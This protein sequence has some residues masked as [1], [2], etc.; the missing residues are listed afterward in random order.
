MLTTGKLPTE[1][2]RPLPERDSPEKEKEDED[3][4]SSSEDEED[5][6]ELEA[7]ELEPAQKILLDPDPAPPLTKARRRLTNLKLQ[8]KKLRQVIGWLEAELQC[9]GTRRT[10]KKPS[11]RQ[12]RRRRQLKCLWPKATLNV[13]LLKSR[14]RK[15]KDLKSALIRAHQLL[16]QQKCAAKDFHL[17]GPKMLEQ[18]KIQHHTNDQA[19]AIGAFWRELWE[20]AGSHTPDHPTLQEWG[21]QTIARMATTDKPV[22]YSPTSA[23]E[24]AFKRLKS[25][26]APGP[27][28]IC[29]YW[30]KAFKSMGTK[31]GPLL[32]EHGTQR[33][34]SIPQW[35][36]EGR[37]VLL[38]KGDNPTKPGS[39]RP[40][41]CLNVA[42]KLL[43]GMVARTLLHHVKHYDLLPLE[44]KALKAGCR[45]CFDAVTI[46]SA[47]AAKA[48]AERRDLSMVWLDFQKAFDRVPH[49]W[50]Q[51]A[52]RT[53]KAPREVRRAVRRVM[54]LWRTTLELHGPE[55]EVIR[56]PVNFKRGIYQGDT[57]SPLL[58]G[59]AIAP[60]STA[61]QRGGGFHSRHH[62]SPITHLVYMDDIKVYEQSAE[63]AE[64]TLGHVEGVARAIGMQL[65]AA[66]C[67][68]AHIKRGKVVKRGGIASRI[69]KVNEVTESYRYLGVDQLFGER[70]SNESQQTILPGYTRPGER[71]SIAGRPSACTTPMAWK[72][73]DI[74]AH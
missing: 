61:L 74:C 37:T 56:I 28:Q 54:P 65:G 26:K 15:Q 72:C 16:V 71:D 63:E 25:W 29:G 69:T 46:N 62:N 33:G 36:V 31:L 17:R 41:T 50:I 12:A 32:W 42:Y 11:R 47:L 59:I 21:Q 5:G 1:G 44:Q 35:L 51:T 73:Y 67:G 57:L 20:Q 27:D 30:Y 23:W 22:D 8:R 55:E 68:V 39:R 24:M 40:I 52:L 49:K 3:E 60:L 43:T 19:E 13:S 64:A 7:D 53:I 2:G 10:R 34:E 58:F 4:A 48:K 14:L 66:K 38:P 18:R 70:R 9:I 6:T 45:G